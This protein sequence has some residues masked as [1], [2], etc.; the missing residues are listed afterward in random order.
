GITGG[1]RPC[2]AS[3]RGRAASGECLADPLVALDGLLLRA[4]RDTGGLAAA[5]TVRAGRLGVWAD[6][7]AP[8]LVARRLQKSLWRTAGVSPYT[9]GR[10]WQPQPP[11]PP[12]PHRP[13]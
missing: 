5:A 9:G 3:L 2:A 13:P 1:N 4:G 8:H 11:R 12:S 10:S 7:P 6:D